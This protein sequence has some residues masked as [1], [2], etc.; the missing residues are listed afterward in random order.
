MSCAEPPVTRYNAG[1]WG[2]SDDVDSSGGPEI[3]SRLRAATVTR[4]APATITAMT[5]H[6]G[7]VAGGYRVEQPGLTVTRSRRSPGDLGQSAPRLRHL[8]QDAALIIRPELY[9]CFL[10]RSAP[11]FDRLT[12]CGE[13]WRV[14]LFWV[15]NARAGRGVPHSR[16]ACPC[17]SPVSP[18]LQHLS[19]S[20]ARP[21]LPLASCT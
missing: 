21:L 6:L 1:G 10:I 18:R 7:N 16:L 11:R 20:Q 14:Y 19:T 5:I 15:F 17:L 8:G 12:D 2:L 9:G 3:H 4:Q 13:L